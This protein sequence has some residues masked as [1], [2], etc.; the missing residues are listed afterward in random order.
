MIDAKEKEKRSELIVLMW[1]LESVRLMGRR[2]FGRCG[3]I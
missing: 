1:E 3:V 2:L